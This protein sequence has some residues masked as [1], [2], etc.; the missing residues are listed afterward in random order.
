MIPWSLPGL[1]TALQTFCPRVC[2]RQCSCS[3]QS[4]SQSQSLNCHLLSSVSVPVCGR[5]Y[6]ELERLGWCFV[7]VCTS[8]LTLTCV[9]HMSLVLLLLFVFGIKGH[10]MYIVFILWEST[11]HKCRSTPVIMT[12]DS[13]ARWRVLQV[14]YLCVGKLF[15]S[16]TGKKI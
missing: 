5:G 14:I 6:T 3:V 15:A 16:S 12:T 9:H 4:V 10:L 1:Y 13:W 7:I 11:Q 8:D 2:Q